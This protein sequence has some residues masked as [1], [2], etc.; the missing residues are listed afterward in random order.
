MWFVCPWIG[1]ASDYFT[2]LR[3]HHLFQ[4]GKLFEDRQ[5]VPWREV[6]QMLNHIFLVKT[7]KELNQQQLNYMG[8]IAFSEYKG[9]IAFS[10]YKGHI[11]FSEYKGHIAFIEYKG[12][13]AFSEYKGHIAFSEYLD[14]VSS[15]TAG[16]GL[17]F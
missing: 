11:A 8:H 2:C 1:G 10:E 3:V 6:A 16:D 12:H 14:Q 5:K 7:G 13:I 9:H 15:K 4:N 17:C